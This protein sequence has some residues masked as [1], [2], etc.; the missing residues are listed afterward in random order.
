MA[1]GNINGGPDKLPLGPPCNS[2]PK[3]SAPE[4]KGNL[5]FLAKRPQEPGSGSG[6]GP[7][8]GQEQG[9]EGS[10]DPVNVD[11]N[12]SQQQ[13]INPSPAVLQSIPSQQKQ[14]IQ[15]LKQKLIERQKPVQDQIRKQ[16]KEKTQ[17]ILSSAFGSP[18]QNP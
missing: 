17:A 12:L 1:K 18:R 13:S 3:V 10:Q 9:Q 7:G 15:Q 8:P 2:P 11:P 6:S 5:M 16:M 4:V 14:D